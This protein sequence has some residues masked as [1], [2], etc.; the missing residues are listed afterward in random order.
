[1]TTVLIVDDKKN[2]LLALKRILRRLNVDIVQAST[3]QEALLSALNHDFALAI[4]DVQMPE[5]DGYELATLLRSDAASRDVP[6]IFLSAVCSTEPYVCRGYESGAVD[7]I[8]KPFNPDILLSKARVFLELHAQKTALAAQKDQLETMVAKLGE[9]VAARRR[10]E[11]RLIKA[12]EDLERKVAERTARTAKMVEALKIANAKLAVR[13]KQLRAL[14]GELTMAEH[15]ERQRV[16]RILHDGL[17]QHLAVA[18]L[19]LGVM[20]DQ[21]VT[22]ELK[23][24]AG[25]VRNL[26]SESI[27]MSRSLSAELSPPIIHNNDL[28]AGL[29]WLAAWMRNNHGLSIDLAI[30][31][32]PEL[33]EDVK[34]LVFESVRELLFNTAKHADVSKARVSLEQVDGS[35]MHI[36]I[37]DKGAGFDPT[38]LKPAGDPGAGFGLFSIRERIGLIGGSLYIVSSP[39]MG[40]H[41]TLMVPLRH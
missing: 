15:R 34:I 11:E 30:Q 10:A 22:D 26:I 16:S 19:R 6:I 38:R 14:A 28:S 2:N 25:Q 27:Q 7:Y 12:N 17:Q 36:C 35:K 20:A 5:M 32:R 41:F 1:M 3:G 24:V 40:S 33:P 9:Q 39:G 31:D 8:T 13:T 18:K 23:R 4:L 37:S 29:K 21:L